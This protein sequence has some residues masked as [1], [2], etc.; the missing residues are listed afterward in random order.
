MKNFPKRGIGEVLKFVT[1]DGGI[2][3]KRQKILGILQ[4]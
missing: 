3:K 2:R 4:K 1:T